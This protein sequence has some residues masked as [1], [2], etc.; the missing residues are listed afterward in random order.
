M[1]S[2]NRRGFTL[3]ELLVVIA[4]IGMLSTLAVVALSSARQK[5][6]DAKRVSDAKAVESALGLFN[7]EN[8]GYPKVAAEL[9][10]SGKCISGTNGIADACAGT[11]FLEKAPADPTGAVGFQYLGTGCGATT[12]TDFTLKFTLEGNT[13]DYKDT[14]GDVNSVPNCTMTSTSTSCI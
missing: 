5:G 6:R 13:G 2:R 14:G 8:N 4:I 10:I 11:K 1:R 7:V 12:C 3:I 9:D